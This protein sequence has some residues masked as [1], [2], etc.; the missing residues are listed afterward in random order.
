MAHSF[1]HIA[2][3]GF[4]LGADHRRAF[5][6]AAQ[7]FTQVAAAA[8]KGHLEVV[9]VDMVR[10]IGRGEHFRLIDVIDPD[11]FQDLRLDKVT[12]AAFR[13]HRDRD[14]IHDLQDQFGVAHARHAAVGAD[15]RRNTLQRHHCYCA[16]FLCNAGMLRCDYIH[17]HAT[18]QHLRQAFLDCKGA[19]FLIHF[20]PPD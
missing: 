17:N 19:D 3:A 13:H 4:A 20:L 5:A 2:G 8:N 14:R 1:D 16:S 12:D 9:L 15:I 7:R 18:L 6:D 11:R 10:F